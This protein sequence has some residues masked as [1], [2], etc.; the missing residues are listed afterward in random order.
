LR[1]EPAKLQLEPD[2]KSNIG[3]SAT[4]VVVCRADGGQPEPT[5]HWSLST[6]EARRDEVMSRL[7][8]RPAVVNN[9]QVSV[10]KAGSAGGL[11][12]IELRLANATLADSGLTVTCLAENA[13]GISRI[14][15]TIVVHEPSK[16]SNFLVL[17]ARMREISPPKVSTVNCAVC[18]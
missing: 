14:N 13:A 5:V 10:I 6:P 11:T 3:V 2:S 16:F 1:A 4:A 9:E 18:S 17:Y 12:A 15:W 8:A 7:T